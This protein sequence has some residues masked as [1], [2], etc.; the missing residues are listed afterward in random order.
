MAVTLEE[1]G[2]SAYNGAATA[3]KSPDLLSAAGAVVQVEARHAGAL[4]ELAGMDPAPV[5]FDKTLSPQQVV[6]AVKPF[7]K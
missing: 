4:R 7:L 1:V 2:I 6:A 3:I 5:A